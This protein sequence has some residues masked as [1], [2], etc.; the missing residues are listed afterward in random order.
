MRCSV[1]TRSRRTC[2]RTLRRLVSPAIQRNRC[3]ARSNAAPD[4]SVPRRGRR[5]TRTRWS[6]GAR[7]QLASAQ[8]SAITRSARS[9]SPPTLRTAARLRTPRRWPITRRH[10]RR[11]S[12]A[13]DATKSAS[14]RS[15]GSAC[16]RS[17][18]RA[19]AR[20]LHGRSKRVTRSSLTHYDG[21]SVGSSAAS[22]FPS[23]DPSVAE[24]SG[25]SGSA[26]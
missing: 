1:I 13:A 12:L 8:R 11:S 21:S 26:G 25:Q 7:S 17:R 16:G 15:S 5:R 24:H 22:P 9:G 10:V 20:M 6:A 14:T 19:V 18:R 23:R 3:S 2:M 4:S